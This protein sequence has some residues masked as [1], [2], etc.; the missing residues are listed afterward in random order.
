[1]KT[2]ILLVED[3]KELRDGLQ[4]LLRGLHI[5]VLSAVNGQEAVDIMEKMD[6]DILL[7][8]V[9]MPVMDGISLLDWVVKKRLDTVVILLTAYGDIDQAVTAIKKGAYDY[10]TKPIDI[11]RLENTIKRAQEKR[12]LM[13]ENR[14][15][16]KS[17]NENTFKSIVGMSDEVKILL[18]K[19]RQYAPIDTNILITGETGVGK[20]MI[21]GVI[22]SLSPRSSKPF[23]K[24]SCAALPETLLESELFGFEKGS[25]TGA[26]YSKKGRFEI[27][28]GGT[29]LLNEVE[30]LSLPIQAKL[31]RVIEE[32][33]FERIGGEKTLKADVRIIS[34]ANKDLM[35]LVDE[36]AF[37]EDLYYRLKVLCLDVPPLRERSGDI[38]LLLHH[39]LALYSKTF[40]KNLKG[41]TKDAVRALCEYS[42]PGNVR[43]LQHF[44]E[45]ITIDV[46][47]SVIRKSDIPSHIL[48]GGM[49]KEK[50]LTFEPGTPLFEMEKEAILHTL[51][52][53]GGNKSKTA[54]L[55][56][57]GLKTLYRKL[58]DTPLSK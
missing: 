55:L 43:E 4:V 33:N 15:L 2:T 13:L 19:I 46:N 39:F 12:E 16:K 10:L 57:I 56:G 6:V 49:P 42:W 11:P 36:G 50:K 47:G 38:P 40:K 9:V 54:E 37:R 30:S 21:A 14:M 24:V 31:L 51:R 27:A 41:F 5:D 45:S 29:I 7:A 52:L 35:A 58:S 22:H 23:I 48:I 32:K 53:T 17:L 1:M 34:T 26:G 3:Q 28:D 20:D 18:D 25:F 44:V 8:D